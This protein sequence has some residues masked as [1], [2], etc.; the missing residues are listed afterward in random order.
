MRINL[1][2]LKEMSAG[3]TDLANEMINIFIE[4]VDEFSTLLTEHY[5]NEEYVK[6]GRLAHKAKASISIM[7]LEE[8]ATD[9]KRLELLAVEGKDKDQY[10]IIINRFKTETDEAVE[11]L[12][13]VTSNIELYL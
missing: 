4:Q 11:E 1:A 9:L 3:N 6:L 7:G 5:N 2:Y 13:E 12:K 10:P 8:L